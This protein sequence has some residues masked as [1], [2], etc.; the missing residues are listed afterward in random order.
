MLVYLRDDVRKEILRPPKQDEIPKH[1]QEVFDKEN[2]II[3]SMQ[4]E[5]DV[6]NE[7]GFVYLVSQEIIQ[8][9]FMSGEESK[10]VDMPASMQNNNEFMDNPLHRVKIK[11]KMRSK[12][13]DLI[14]KVQ[15]FTNS[16]NDP[17]LDIYLFRVTS[18]GG[19]GPNKFL[20]LPPGD[21]EDNLFRGKKETEV[22][23]IRF[24]SSG[25]E[26]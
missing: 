25:E 1:L 12:I 24:A 7:C 2:E 23:Y 11:M 4:K 14:R 18:R 21:S 13:S 3:D 26:K 17:T 8:S 15:Q 19:R 20:Y 9:H 10:I 6:H 16:Y 22:F 5:L